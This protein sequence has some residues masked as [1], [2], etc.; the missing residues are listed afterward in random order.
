MVDIVARVVADGDNDRTLQFKSDDVVFGGG[1]LKL[2]HTVIPLTFEAL[3]KVYAESAE[4]KR[5]KNGETAKKEEPKNDETPAQPEAPAPVVEEDE[6]TATNE[7]HHEVADTEEQPVRRRRGRP[8]KVETEEPKEAEAKEP[9][10]P[11][12]GESEEP[13][14]EQPVRRRRRVVEE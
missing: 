1:R 5:G 7:D 12:Q 3:E 2:T 8:R 10:A 13:A 14:I 9:E 6:P 4:M 11:R